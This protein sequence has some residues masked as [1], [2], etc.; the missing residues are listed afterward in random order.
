ME[1]KKSL[2]IIDGM[3][4][5]FRSFYAMGTRLTNAEG[6]PIGA[7]YGFLKIV[8][9]ILKEQNPTHFAVCWDLKIKT[10]R[11]EAYPEYKGNRGE[12]PPE[13]IPQIQMIHECIKNMGIPSFAVPG[14][15]A[16]DVVATLAKYF[17]H[18]GLVYIVSS[19]KDFMQLVNN[20][21]RLF[22]LKKGDEY[23][24][25]G[26]ESVFDYFGVSPE[27]VVDI[28]ALVGDKSDNVPGVLGIGEK[29]AAKIINEFDS[30][31]N[32]YANLEKIT[33]KKARLALE[34]HRE[35]AFLSRFLVTIN[36]SVPLN[37]SEASLKYSFE[38]L[39]NEQTLAEL[40]KANMQSLIK[41][42]FP[43]NQVNNK[44]QNWEKTHYKLILHWDDVVSICARICDPKTPYFALDTETTGLDTIENHPIGFSICF[45]PGEAYFVPAHKAFQQDAS[46]FEL[47]TDVRPNF[48]AQDVWSALKTALSERTA[49][50]IAHNLK[51]DLHMLA[52]VG[53]TLGNKSAFACSMVAAWL[54]NSAMPGGFSLDALTLKF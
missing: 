4:L 50:V 12:P 22:S 3:S 41:L 32:L 52:N 15:E 39:K 54:L 36:T 40:Q 30:L 20:Q 51:F 23:D 13:I 43:N 27:R 2:Y 1:E 16:D 18:Y 53:I 34:A 37:I 48:A 7:V 29:G 11:H 10:F 5:L 17:E 38:D 9:K 49:L 46:C 6:V 28:L 25:L 44:T 8:I 42:L 19:D 31:E 21:I 35:M 24:V 45:S 33:N 47:A 14:F 26:P